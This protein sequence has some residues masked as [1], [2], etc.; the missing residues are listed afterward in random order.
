MKIYARRFVDEFRPDDEVPKGRYD[1]ATLS[2]LLTKGHF[3]IVEDAEPATQAEQDP[4]KAKADAEKRREKAVK[5]YASEPAEQPAT[6]TVS[7][8]VQVKRVSAPSPAP[9]IKAEPTRSRRAVVET[10]EEAESETV[11]RQYVPD[12]EPEPEAEP[13]AGKK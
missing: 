2:G 12:P 8:G 7:E 3:V 5:E 9:A 4:E 11:T 6:V 13:K 10:I 1:E